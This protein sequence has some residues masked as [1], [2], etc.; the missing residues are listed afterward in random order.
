[1]LGTIKLDY[2]E[3]TCISEN[4]GNEIIGW[5]KNCIEKDISNKEFRVHTFFSKHLKG[6]SS[7]SEI[8][9]IPK[10]EQ[11]SVCFVGI[12]CRNIWDKLPS[13]YKVVDNKNFELR[14]LDLKLM[15]E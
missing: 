13:L 6:K 2:L 14:R 9:L 12:G 10:K 11:F 8:Y 15:A 3:F 1:M 5:Y 4:T 7:E